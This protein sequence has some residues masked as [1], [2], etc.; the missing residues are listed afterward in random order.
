MVGRQRSSDPASGRFTPADID[1]V[2]SQAWVEFGDLSKD[3]PSQPTAGSRLN[4]RLACLTLAFFRALIEY[5]VARAYAIELT[6]DLT[7]SFYRKWGALRRFLRRGNPLGNFEGLSPGYVVPL[8]FPFNPPGY[9]AHWS[10]TPEAPIGFDVVQCP[11]SELFR[12]HNAAD[13]CVGSWCNLDYPLGE[14]LG[15][16]L[17][18][19]KTLVEGSD[20]CTFRWVPQRAS[21]K[22]PG[23]S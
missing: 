12:S 4:I 13:L 5:G 16:K 2:V 15:L 20:R 17:T 19:E 6:A 18:R 21:P 14:A 3:L 10:P 11:V 8:P 22:M 9:A 7:W 23:L 1:R